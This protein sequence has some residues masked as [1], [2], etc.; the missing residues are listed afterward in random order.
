MVSTSV[1]VINL[2]TPTLIE[3]LQT[4]KL[5]VKITGVSLTAR[6]QNASQPTGK[7][8]LVDQPGKS[9]STV[10]LLSAALLKR[11]YEEQPKLYNPLIVKLSCWSDCCK[12]TPH[13]CCQRTASPGL[14]L[15]LLL[16]PQAA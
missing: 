9:Q 15:L 5:P 2:P 8:H 3:E 4:C 14:K 10:L 12:L 11:C 1:L 7:L 16:A 13:H 6:S